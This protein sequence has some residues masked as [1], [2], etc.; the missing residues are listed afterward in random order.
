MGAAIAGN[1]PDPSARKALRKARVILNE[2][3]DVKNP[4]IFCRV[5]NDRV[6]RA[7]SYPG[8]CMRRYLPGVS[9]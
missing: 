1:L 5:Q 8:A 6:G 2:V 3:R 4:G 9:A 7:R